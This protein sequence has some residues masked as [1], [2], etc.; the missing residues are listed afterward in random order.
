[1]NITFYSNLTTIDK[2]NRYLPNLNAQC[3]CIYRLDERERLIKEAC[4]T[5]I[6]L[7]DAMG[8]VDSEII[9][10]MPR[11][12]LI[13][14]EGVG[15][16]GIDTAFAKEK[17]IPVCNN[18]GVNDTAVAEV[19]LLLMLG[20][21]KS[22][23]T[24]H[25]SVYDGRQIEI[26]KASFGVIR[27]L[28]E[29]TVGLIGFGDIAKR[30]ALLA[31]AFG[32]RVIYTNRTRYP[33]LEKQYNVTYSDLDSLL[34]QSDF[35]S[36]HLAV[37]E[38]TR[39]MANADF[40]SKMKSTAFLINT[41]RGDLVDNNALLNALLNGEIAGAGLDV[42]SPEPVTADNILLDERI[43]DRLVLTPHIAGI[44]SLTIEKIYKSINEN[45]ERIKNCKEPKNRV[46]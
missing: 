29:C 32:A 11:L 36:L 28:G 3:I 40:L 26:K 10:S 30:T 34:N 39:E 5:E 21:L 15:Y 35:V 13:M 33:E 17:G 6:L 44:T 22:I 12:K 46:N 37:T 41:S 2:I 19:A 45:I 14:S 38:Q 4:D 42:I 18:K 27:E 25:Q 16:Q 7:V 23:I 8:V 24:G 31:N 1:M 20:C 9:S 43:K